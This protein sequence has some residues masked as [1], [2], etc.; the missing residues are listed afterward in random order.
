L[1]SLK[2]GE[3]AMNAHQSPQSFDFSV[4]PV[5]KMYLDSV[6]AWKKNYEAFTMNPKGVQSIY[7]LDSAKTSY[8]PPFPGWHK[9]GE[10]FFKRF[11]EQQIELCRF[12][13]SRWEQYLKL[14]DQLAQCHSPAD[15]G[16]VQAA[17][18]NQAANDY[19]HEA[20]KLAQPMGEFTS[21]WTVNR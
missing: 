9:T 5:M 19:M 14:S 4:G 18:M 21:Y 10:E 16:Q 7:S 15:F 17:F 3:A 20:A 1:E 6:E 13:A 8:E 12:F 11:V 2:P